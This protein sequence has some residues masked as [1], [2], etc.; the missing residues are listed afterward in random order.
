MFG[1]GMA[2]R[3]DISSGPS[4]DRRPRIEVH[5]TVGAGAYSIIASCT[6][7]L[8]LNELAVELATVDY[9]WRRLPGIPVVGLVTALVPDISEK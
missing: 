8:A 1:P 5:R 7:Y 2:S 6:E 9:L 3:A 4:A